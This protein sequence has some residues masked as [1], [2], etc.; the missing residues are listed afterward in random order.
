V[1]G[2]PLPKTA[3]ALFDKRREVEDSHDRYG[4]I[5]INWLLQ[6]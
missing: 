3:D 6:A 5:E 1:A 2:D 4:N